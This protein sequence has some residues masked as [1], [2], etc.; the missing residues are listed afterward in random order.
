MEERM[1]PGSFLDRP[2]RQLLL[3]SPDLLPEVWPQVIPLLLAAKEIWEEYYTLDSLLMLLQQKRMQLWTMNDENEFILALLTELLIFPKMKVLHI[4]FIAGNEL[5][6]GLEFFDC[7]EMWARKQG[8]MRSYGI[9]RKGFLR[10]LR[11][12]GYVAKAVTF[13]KDISGMVEH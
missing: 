11:P 9:G 10:V 1:A 2:I 12:Y 5:K 13:E 4:V 8:A 7:I 3:V 6:T